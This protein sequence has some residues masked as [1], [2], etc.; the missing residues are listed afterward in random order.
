MASKRVSYPRSFREQYF[1]CRESGNAHFIKVRI[2]K[3]SGK[4][5][6]IMCD[7]YKKQCSSDVCLAER[8]HR[9]LQLDGWFNNS[10]ECVIPRSDDGS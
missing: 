9:A 5:E 7:K 10:R 4:V 2:P 8:K 6:V 3:V 1:E